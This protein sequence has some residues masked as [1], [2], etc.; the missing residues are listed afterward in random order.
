MVTCTDRGLKAI[1]LT[2]EALFVRTK[3]KV[4]SPLVP[5]KTNRERPRVEHISMKSVDTLEPPLL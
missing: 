1:F 2:R 3:S 5:L 4:L